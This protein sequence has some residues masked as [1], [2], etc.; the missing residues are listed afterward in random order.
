VSLFALGL[1]CWLF[2]CKVIT[3]DELLH[4][5]GGAGLLWLANLG[6]MPPLTAL[7]LACLVVLIAAFGLGREIWQHGDIPRTAHV[8]REALAWPVG[9]A[10]AALLV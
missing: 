4:V 9:A 7:E 5:A 8:W 3:G 2:A 6:L 1:F 10:V